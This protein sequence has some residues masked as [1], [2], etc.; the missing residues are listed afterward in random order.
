NIDPNT[1]KYMVRARINADGIIEKPDVVGAIFGQ[2]EGLLGDELDL[3]DLQKSGRIG[4]IEVE[5]VSKA[6]KSD[7]IIYMSSSLDQVE[8]VI[9]AS[10]LET[11]DRVGPC[12][13]SIHVLGIEDVRVTKREKVVERAKELL[14]DLIKQSKGSS[15]DLMDSVRQSVQ[16][17]EI[18]VYG[19]D[20]CPAGPN[21][22]DSEAI[23]IVEGRSDVLNLLKAGIKN[24]IAVEGTNI[25]KT[26]QDLSK[27][28]VAT[29]F[30]DGD[31]GGEL[32]LRELFQVAEV[33]F[34][35]RAPRAHEVEEL[36]A[37]QIVKCLRNKV[38][39]DQYMEMNGLIT[40]EK[41][42]D[43]DVED[44]RERRERRDRDEDRD[45][46]RE[47]RERREDD[48]DERRD[49]RE[50]RD[51]DRDER[52]ERRER[53]DRDEDRDER[54]EHKSRFDNDAIE[55]YR[56]KKPESEDVPAIPA[57]EE[58]A[59][60]EAPEEPTL[61]EAPA[62][63]EAQPK[64][65][66]VEE[67]K[68]KARRTLRGKKSS[69]KVL[70]PE[71]TQYRDMLLDL[72]TTHNAKILGEGNS[73]IR[74][75]AVKNLVNSLKEDSEGAVA[76]VFDGVISQRILD[77]SADKGITTVIGTRKGNISKM[78]AEITIWTK[79]DLY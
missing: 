5:V 24:A 51:E 7:G 76:I 8:T 75:V 32:I 33:D 63:E 38:P 27:E 9:L 46:R 48:R 21:V 17:E 64:E 61:I 22:K 4:R 36:T 15:Y 79:E 42:L 39:G 18:T 68:P 77:I 60:I 31:R 69:D 49:R 28:R 59:M 72:A 55:K 3:R 1:T 47:R 54:R 10:A 58:P 20:R 30:V 71:Q 26:I 37:K 11:V 53:R 40:E 67:P 70:S 29:A 25:P 45:E 50:R 66:P 12:R 57:A 6:G 74:E 14:N 35:A 43:E 62:A 78:P 16:V 41:T 65:E 44:R 52:R 34:V 2:T 19:K 23:I 73:V 13:A 56:K